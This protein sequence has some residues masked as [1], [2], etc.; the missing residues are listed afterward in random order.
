M[1]LF[2]I[3][4]LALFSLPTYIA[5]K[6]LRLSLFFF[7]FASNRNNI[8]VVLTRRYARIPFSPHALLGGHNKIICAA[9]K[10]NGIKEVGMAMKEQRSARLLDRYGWEME[11][12]K[13]D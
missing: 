4:L 11:N 3:S 10:V 13:F 9:L 5:K 1:R 7:I 8:L 2:K 12:D 6:C